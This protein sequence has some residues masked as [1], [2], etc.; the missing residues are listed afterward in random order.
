MDAGADAT[1]DDAAGDF[2]PTP[3]VTGIGDPCLFDDDCP[4]NSD[5]VLFCSR[6]CTTDA[7]CAGGHAGGRNAQGVANHCVQTL[8]EMTGQTFKSCFP[9]CNDQ[10]NCDALELVCQAG[11][12]ASGGTV[13]VCARP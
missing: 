10:S 1:T 2:A 6:D 8:N 5:C 7:D 4:L 3:N 13:M 9:G 11:P 12:S